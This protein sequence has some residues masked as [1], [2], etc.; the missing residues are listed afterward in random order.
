M[1][2]RAWGF[3]SPLEHMINKDTPLGS[4]II[5]R[6]GPSYQSRD[7]SNQERIL[8]GF[9]RINNEGLPISVHLAHPE[10]LHNYLAFD[11]V[12]LELVESKIESM[13]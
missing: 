2:V 5:I 9:G 10:Y 11:N 1:P 12:Y 6:T 8:V 3:E 4:R 7:W 13:Y